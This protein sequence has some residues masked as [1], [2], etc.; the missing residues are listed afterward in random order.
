[1]KKYVSAEVVTLTLDC[2]IIW[3][4]GYD[5]GIVRGTMGVNC[6]FWRN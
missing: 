5:R 1:M 2:W 6:Y 3:T 4:F